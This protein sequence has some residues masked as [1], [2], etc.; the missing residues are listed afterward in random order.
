MRP[1]EL[2]DRIGGGHAAHEQDRAARARVVRLLRPHLA[3]DRPAD[4][5]L[6]PE[7]ERERRVPGVGVELVDRAVAEPAAAAARNG[8][9]A[10]DPSER[11]DAGLDRGLDLGLVREVRGVAVGASAV[12][13]DPVHERSDVVVRPRRDEDRCALLGEQLRRGG[14]DPRRP[15]HEADKAGEAVHAAAR[16]A[17]TIPARSAGVALTI[18]PP[19]PTATAPAARKAGPVDKSTPPVGISSTSGIGP[20]SSRT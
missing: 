9:E 3:H 18:A 11:R 10:V 1:E 12:P 13:G 8:E 4:E 2:R 17:A 20:R 5:R 6:G 15:G 7:V 16:M 14:G 19:I